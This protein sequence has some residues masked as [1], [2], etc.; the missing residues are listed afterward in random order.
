MAARRNKKAISMAEIN[1][2]TDRVIAGVQALKVI[3]IVQISELCCVGSAAYLCWFSLLAWL[4][5]VVLCCVVLCCVVLCCVV[6]CCVVCLFV[7]L[8]FSWLFF[9]AC[10]CC[11]VLVPCF[12]CNFCTRSDF[13]RILG[14]W[15]I[16]PIP[17]GD[18]QEKFRR[19]RRSA[20]LS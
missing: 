11:V 1:D 3:I 9:F 14:V 17:S 10:F 18:F 19:F 8:F 6:L 15:G 12:W 16:P 7:S 4:C 20:H 13:L 5:C 2:A